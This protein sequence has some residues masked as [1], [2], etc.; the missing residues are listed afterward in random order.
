M[1]PAVLLLICFGAG[2]ATGLLRFLASQVIAFGACSLLLLPRRSGVAVWTWAFLLGRAAAAI[3]LGREQGQCAAQLHPGPIVVQARVIEPVEADQLVG[4]AQIE[5]SCPGSIPVRW[6]GGSRLPAGSRGRLEGRWILADSTDPQSGILVAQRFVPG[7]VADLDPGEQL[8]NW[9]AATVRRLYGQRAAL[10]EALLLNRRSGLS[11][12]LRDRYARAGLVH[13]LSISGFHVGV[14]IGW[15]LLAGRLAGLPARQAQ[16][17]A[18]AVALGYVVF[19]GWPPPA[20]RAA[21]LAAL[22]VQFRWR[23]RHPDNLAVLAGSCLIVLLLDPRAALSPGAWLSAAALAGA[24]LA[25]GWSD[26]ALGTGWG[27]RLLASSVGATVATAPITAAQFGM[28]SV[29]GVVLNFV[30][31]PLA[32]LA[33][34]GVMLSLLA[35]VLLPPLAAPLAAGSGALLALLDQVAWLGGGWSFSAIMQPAEPLSAVPWLVLLAA[36]GW[37]LHGHTRRWLALR[38]AGSVLCAAVWLSA[39]VEAAARA[40][41]GGSGLA[42][43]FLDVGQGDAALIRTPH[44]QWVL[45]DA[46][47]RSDRDDA[48]R[49]VVVPFLAT[50]RAPGLAAALVSHAHADHLG[51]MAAVLR[52]FPVHTLL[53]PAEL[54]ADPMYTGLLD[55][56]AALG[57]T[58][59]PARDGLRFEIDSVHFSVLHPDTSWSEWRLDLNEDSIVLLVEYRDFR[60]LLVGDAGIRAESRL[61]HR[62]G[63]VDLLKVG[64][65]GSATASSDAWLSELSPWA[66]VISVGRGNRYGHPNP[67]TLERLQRHGAGIW[68]TD[69]DG[70]IT[71]TTDGRRI[72]IAGRDRQAERVTPTTAQPGT[73]G[74]LQPALP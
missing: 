12:E 67:A 74:N 17:L 18:V 51:G 23:Q 19:L 59:Q 1:P 9:V 71:V 33:V 43:H 70:T 7:P 50:H 64:H 65:H 52:R 29:T 34:P 4:Q 11:P 24:M 40:H 30:A 68:R 54:V 3:T 20:A 27:W 37:S 25:T 69:R 5:G 31:I 38:R 2:L 21:I 28:V 45:V 14:I 10:V 47:P 32:A 22:V 66:A 41:D 13:I 44:G 26:R 15:I 72:V 62:V 63:R 6:P 58:W 48:G 42:L 73:P 39:G 16:L 61:A 55:Q 8:R 56:L 49:R 36:A 57:E 35:A 60:A 53:E 46:G